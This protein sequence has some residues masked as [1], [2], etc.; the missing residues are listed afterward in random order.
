MRL[1]QLLAILPA[2]AA[3]GASTAQAAPTP[4]CAK[5][6]VCFTKTFKGA[7]ITIHVTG[8][9]GADK[10]VVNNRTAFG[11]NNLPTIEVNGVNTFV[12][13]SHNAILDVKGLGGDDQISMPTLTPTGTGFVLYGS[14]TLD[15]GDGNDVITGAN[16]PDTLIGGAGQDVLDGGAGNDTFLALDGAADVLR[17]G[18]GTDK[19]QADAA[20]TKDSIEA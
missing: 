5:D 2:V 20:D 16:R 8:T 17:G 11:N 15:G 13:S 18:L 1:I 3:F 9:A 19:A 10:I 7:D 4:K 6:G 12:S 14:A